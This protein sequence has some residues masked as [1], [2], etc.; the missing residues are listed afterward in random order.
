M[1]CQRFLKIIHQQSTISIILVSHKHFPAAP[2]DC[3]CI[4]QVPWL[5]PQCRRSSLSISPSLPWCFRQDPYRLPRC[6]PSTWELDALRDWSV[7]PW[8]DDKNLSSVRTLKQ[9]PGRTEPSWIR[10][11][12]GSGSS[13]W[14]SICP[15]R[16]H[17]CGISPPDHWW[18]S[19][20]S[21]SG[22]RYPRSITGIPASPRWL[23]EMIILLHY[24]VRLSKWSREH[25]LWYWPF[26]NPCLGTFSGFVRSSIRVREHFHGLPFYLFKGIYRETEFVIS[27][28]FYSF[29]LR[30]LSA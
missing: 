23:E 29:H 4:G 19:R 12:P 7:P 10:H 25:F 30:C 1:K 26:V 18:T 8:A 15:L 21:H 11:L 22:S 20:W 14:R 28:I 13:V 24:S 3:G 5:Q 9:S 6:R 16:F 27:L 2:S 17:K